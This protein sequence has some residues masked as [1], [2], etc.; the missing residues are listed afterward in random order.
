MKKPLLISFSGGRTSAYMT[1]KLMSDDEILREFQPHIVFANTGLEHPKTLNFINQ[2]EKHFGWDVVWLE[3]V[4][5]PEKGKGTQHKIVNYSSASRCGEPFFD[6]VAKYT[7]PNVKFRHCT[8]ELKQAPIFSYC[9]ERFGAVNIDV[10]IGIRTDETRR[11]SQARNNKQRVMYP[12]IDRY[13]TDKQDVLDFWA[14]MPFDLGLPEYLGNCV[15][16]FQKSDKKLLKALQDCPDYFDLIEQ[17]EQEFGIK[18]DGQIVHFFRGNRDVAHLRALFDEI[19]SLPKSL[20][21]FDGGACG[22]SC[23]FLGA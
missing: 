19:G 8:R 13:P 7:M 3:A 16:C 9:R 20:N 10:A 6:V 22:E 1:H 14:D 23:E 11:V 5:Q 4:V 12:L 17:M 2:C 18:S 15:P 21:L